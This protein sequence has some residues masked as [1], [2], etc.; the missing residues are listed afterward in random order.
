MIALPAQCVRERSGNDLRLMTVRG[1]VNVCGADELHHLLG[2]DEAIVE[3]HARLHSHF[4]R[5]R[6][7]VLAIL[8]PFAS[9]NVRVSR[10][11]HDVNDILVF[12]QDLRHRFDHVLDS[13]VRGEQAEG[14]ENRLSLHTEPVLIEIRINE[15]Q[16]GN[17][18]GNHVDLAAGNFED[19]L[20]ELRR[21]LAHHDQPVGKLSNLFHHHQLVWI[22]LAKDGMQS[23]HDRHLQTTQKMQDV[24]SSRS[25][26]DSVLVLQADHVDIVE[27]QEAS[28][29]FIRRDFVL[30]E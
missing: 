21:E 25:A 2:T 20:Q 13:L 6:L 18:V 27:V 19:F 10:A 17:S 4:F 9:E 24:T 7:Q 28:G 23:C 30:V 16:V 22:R 15:R 12:R 11:R 3:K 8:I 1:Y 29:F 5:E 26:K 14:E